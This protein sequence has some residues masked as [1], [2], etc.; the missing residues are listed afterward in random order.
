MVTQT[1]SQ[2]QFYTE[3]PSLIQSV[4]PYRLPPVAHPCKHAAVT[5][6]THCSL[7]LGGSSYPRPY[8]RLHSCPLDIET[9]T[10]SS[11]SHG[12]EGTPGHSE[13]ISSL[14][15]ASCD[16]S[17]TP[18]MASPCLVIPCRALMPYSPLYS[19]HPA[20]R[21]YCKHSINFG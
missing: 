8:D 15:R 6:L 19:S 18:L 2:S 21:T 7:R 12:P 11:G 4:P 1:I 13:T 20:H 17:I 10:S 14:P 16:Y 3:A 9:G 5:M